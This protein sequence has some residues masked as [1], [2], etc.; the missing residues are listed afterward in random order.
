MRIICFTLL[1]VIVSDAEANFYCVYFSF[2]ILYN[3]GNIKILKGVTLIYKKA[4]TRVYNL[5][6]VEE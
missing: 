3:I 5:I 2:S 1:F 6:I 4:I